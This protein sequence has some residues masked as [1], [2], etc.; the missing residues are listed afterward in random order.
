MA[1]LPSSHTPVI[2]E[3][4]YVTIFQAATA[5]KPGYSNQEAVMRRTALQVS[6]MMAFAISMAIVSP[7]QKMTNDRGAALSYNAQAVTQIEGRR[8]EAA[9]ELLNKAISLHPDFAAAYYNLGTAYYLL[10]QS[11]NAVAALQEA[12]KLNHPY[13]EAYN[14]LGVVYVELAQYERA[15]AAFKQST[16][17]NPNDSIARYNLGCTYIRLKDFKAAVAALDRA[18][19]L[20]PNN[21]EARMN[22]AFAYSRLKLYPAAITEMREAVRLKPKDIQAQFFLG[23]L[24]LLAKDRQSALAQYQTVKLLN[25]QMARRLYE[26]I[27]R[28]R[29]VIAAEQ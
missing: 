17:H 26:A 2:T 16:S 23:N 4:F 3:Q 6:L 28:D 12:I 1:K 21:V 18:V 25:P 10:G 20:Q 19:Q 29:V 7:A 14:Q 24:C 9:I 15:I 11:A 13:P 8:Y 5:T 22:L 27:Y